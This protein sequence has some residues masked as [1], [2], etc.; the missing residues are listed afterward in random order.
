MD[1]DPLLGLARRFDLAVIEDATEALGSLYRER[2]VGSLGDVSCFSFNGNKIVTAG[3]GGAIVTDRADWAERARYLTTQAKD[4][5]VEY[6]HNEVGYNYR[7]TNV[8]AVRARRSWNAWMASS[9][10]NEA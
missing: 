9:T 3:G 8:Q 4:D 5:P 7:L 1:A 6:V 10:R 2:H